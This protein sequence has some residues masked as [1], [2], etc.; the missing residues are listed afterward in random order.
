[1]LVATTMEFDLPGKLFDDSS[2]HAI[3]IIEHKKFKKLLK[4]H[5]NNLTNLQ[6]LKINT[7]LFL[8][9]YITSNKNIKKHKL[10]LFYL[11]TLKISFSRK[12]KRKGEK[13]KK[14][15]KYL[16]DT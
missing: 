6:S 8:C 14:D 1:M 9:I 16:I 2:T 10:F 11:H 4:K 13:M 3:L 15:W 7:L 5:S 12:K